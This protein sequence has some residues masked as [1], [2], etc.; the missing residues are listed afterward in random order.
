MT[1]G[2]VPTF[3]QASASVAAGSSSSSGDIPPNATAADPY[4]V[5]QWPGC[6][7]QLMLL[8]RKGLLPTELGLNTKMLPGVY[9]DW[10]KMNISQNNIAISFFGKL[11]KD[12]CEVL[13]T[14]VR[15]DSTRET[16][17]VLA[18]GAAASKEPPTTKDDMV[19]LLSLRAD[20]IA[21]MHWANAAEGTKN[22]RELDAR[23]STSAP[24]R[25]GGSLADVSDPYG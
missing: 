20:P 3:G 21:Q 17:T 18:T 7:P 12:K 8:R 9:K 11:P 25:L 4:S 13:L 14:V 24:D 22:R 5:A 10:S 16:N 15:E 19:R 23:K 6:R 1:F 2:E